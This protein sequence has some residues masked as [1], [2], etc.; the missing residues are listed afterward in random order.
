M[1]R[2]K[3]V[4]YQLY[5]A[6]PIAGEVGAG[7]VVEFV[8]TGKT[9]SGILPVGLDIENAEGCLWIVRGPSL[10]DLGI[11]DGDY[12]VCRKPKK[13]SEITRDTVCVVYIHSIGQHQAKKVIEDSGM[14]ILRSSGGGIPDKAYE[15]DDIEV[16]WI[17][18]GY[19]R[20]KDENGRFRREAREKWDDIPF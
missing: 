2:R 5:P 15:P 9:A 4:Q 20:M 11:F 19:Q 7:K 1:N 13:K 3:P 10:N 8:A 6:L 18:D 12:L 17:V 14:V 16:Q